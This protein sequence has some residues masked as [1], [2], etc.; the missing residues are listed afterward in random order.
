VERE[1]QERQQAPVHRDGMTIQAIH[2]HPPIND[3]I[4]SNIQ[5]MFLSR[6][7]SIVRGMRKI[8]QHFMQ[9]LPTPRVEVRLTAGAWSPVRRDDPR[10]VS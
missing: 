6:E 8:V 9:L 3:S 2:L 5:V 1:K 7:M 10:G 4:L